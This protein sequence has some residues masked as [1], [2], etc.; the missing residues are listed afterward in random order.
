[1]NPHP[2]RVPLCP[3]VFAALTILCASFMAAAQE[4]PVPVLVTVP[5]QG[6]FVARIAGDQ[7]AVEVLVPPGQSHESFE[8]TPR[9]MERIA[10]AQVFF[11]TGLMVE[12]HL[13]PKLKAA[14]PKMR[15]VDSR[16]GI[17]LL[18]IDPEHPQAGTDP[19]VW[20]DP[21]RVKTQ[22]AKIAQ[23]LSELRPGQATAFQE[24]L[25]AF[26]ADLD[27]IAK[28]I[29]TLLEPLRGR[30]V[31]VYHPA[32][33]YFLQ[34]FGL[35]QAAIEQE[36]KEPSLRH[37]Q[38]VQQAIRDDKAR[39]LFVQPQDATKTAEALAANAG[40]RTAPLDAV[41]ADYLENLRKMAR[42][43]QEGLRRAN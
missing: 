33:G 5:P 27:A 13:L 3:S 26:Q 36:G 28:E 42:A 14:G 8:L 2:V 29:Q 6:Y 17:D 18:P 16:D 9:Q 20:L 21:V 4:A 7:A 35:K 11:R 1:M 40:I 39:C 41:A 38:A 23:V 10:R 32:Y 31:F 22:A 19:H 24:R 25:R 30:T 37:I 34:R 12:E 15:V 43:I